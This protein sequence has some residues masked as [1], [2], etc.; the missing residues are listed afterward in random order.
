MKEVFILVIGILCLQIYHVSGQCDDEHQYPIKS[1]E[2]S[3]NSFAM[4]LLKEMLNNNATDENIFFSPFSISTALAMAQLGTGG[5]TARQMENTLK[6]KS[7]QNY[8]CLFRQ[9]LNDINGRNTQYVLKS[10]NNLFPNSKF[11]IDQ[12]YLDDVINYY[13]A[14]IK[15]YDYA[16][17]ASVALKEINEWISNK[18]EGKLKDVLSSVDVNSLTILILVNAIYFKADW[19]HTFDTKNTKPAPFYSPGKRITVNMMMQSFNESQRHVYIKDKDLDAHILELP[20]KG[21]EVSMIIMLPVSNSG[22]GLKTLKDLEEKLNATKLASIQKE[23]DCHNF[24][25]DNREVNLYFPKLL[26]KWRS[27]LVGHLRNLGMVDVFSF[28]A[29]F[30][31]ICHNSDTCGLFFNKVIHQTFVEVN[32][33]GTEAAAVT[34]L[35]QAISIGG[36]PVTLRVDRPFLFL[37]RHKKSK[38]ILFM[39]HITKATIAKKVKSCMTSEPCMKMFNGTPAKQCCG[40]KFQFRDPTKRR[41]EPEDPKVVLRRLKKK[42]NADDCRESCLTE[43]CVEKYRVEDNCQVKNKNKNKNKNKKGK[44]TT[45][46]A[47]P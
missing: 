22:D 10:A 13:S 8:H 17:Q 26:I 25:E 7:G 35:A 20:Y 30:S 33:E 46:T 19:K 41:G 6:F 40:C 15:E 11:K 28:V 23:I 29:N 3:I 34:V 12:T 27:E 44:N 42:C 43:D 1:L 45:A 18:T 24:T 31:R 2:H 9:L 36:G 16:H 14:Q 38:V 5:N 39:G 4:D 21:D 47:K 37:I 32:E